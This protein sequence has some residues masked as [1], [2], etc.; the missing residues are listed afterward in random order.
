MSINE[1]II[2][3]AAVGEVAAEQE[4]FVDVVLAWRLRQ[5]NRRLIRSILGKCAARMARRDRSVRRD[6]RLFAGS[7]RK[8]R[9]F[10]EFR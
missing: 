2:E 6:R 10:Y 4:W 7:A 8:T 9:G 5:V 3:G 1:S